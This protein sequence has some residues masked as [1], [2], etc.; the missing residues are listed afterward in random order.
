MV[1]WRLFRQKRLLFRVK[2]HPFN[3]SWPPASL[4]NF[5]TQATNKSR[6]GSVLQVIYVLL[7]KHN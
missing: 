6:C 5:N 4:T 1:K 3:P 7:L 2:R